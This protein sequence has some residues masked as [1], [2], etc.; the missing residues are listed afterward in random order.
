MSN[1][2]RAVR[3]R[4]VV[5]G[6]AMQVVLALLVLRVPLAAD[7]FQGIAAAA[8]RILSFADA[9]ATYLLGEK[10]YAEKVLG[11]IF[12]FH[13][14]PSIIFFASFMSVLYH[15][16]IM[17]RVV[18]AMSFVM[19]RVLGVSGA[20][21]L[22]MAANVFVGQT[23]APL[24]IRPYVSDMTKSELMT[25]MVGGF[26][27]IAGGV[28]AAYV[29]MLGGESHAERILFAKH[30]LTASVMSAPAAFV[31]AKIIL[32]E[33]EHS[34]TGGIVE[35]EF[36]KT[37][38]N[39]LDAATSGATDG[40]RLAANVGAMLLALIALIAGVDY[41]L[42]WVGSWGWLKPMLTSAG[43]ET[44]NLK[45]IL[46]LIFSPLAW[47]LG[48]Q[49]DD[50]RTFGSL[51][52]EKLVFTEFIAYGSLADVMRSATPM[53]Y[54]SELIATYALCGFANFGSIAIQLGGIGTIAPNRRSDLARFGLRAMLGG[55]MASFMTAAIAG[56]L[57]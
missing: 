37:T 54:R 12:A 44:L 53:H 4:I 33:T 20:E 45:S 14:L 6:I 25:L 51:L 46:G 5:A 32:P 24:V 36:E 40:L 19:N 49:S 29:A 43:I 10:L 41:V 23:E 42:G 35:I 34:K 15:I 17:Q 1:N 57:L 28:F 11:F 7:F 2:R 38:V 9:G 16:G 52:G 47:T 8:T 26:A 56:M 39:V 13:V 50:I 48:V 18:R 55:A 3:W 31:M 30:L 21:S 27:T 22:A